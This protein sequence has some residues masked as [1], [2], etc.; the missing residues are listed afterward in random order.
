MQMH[1]RGCSF[2]RCATVQHA[3][4][5]VEV[6][7]H[8]GGTVRTVSDSCR[9]VTCIRSALN[10]AWLQVLSDG[11]CIRVS[12]P[13]HPRNSCKKL[14]PGTSPQELCPIHLPGQPCFSQ[15]V[16][17]GATLHQQAMHVDTHCNSWATLP[18]YR[19]QHLLTAASD[20]PHATA[21]RLPVFIH[22]ASTILPL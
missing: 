18:A 20:E 3:C 13:L 9:N 1:A 4:N 7:T 12:L 19:Q 2:R 15:C 16:V 8:A 10:E 17:R 5:F 22:A 21:Q 14:M 6:G 11:L